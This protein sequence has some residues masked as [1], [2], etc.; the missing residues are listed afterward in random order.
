MESWEPLLL[1]P[2]SRWLWK[3]QGS[4]AAR[5]GLEICVQVPT[6]LRLCLPNS[7]MDG[8]RVSKALRD[9]VYLPSCPPGSPS[10]WGRSKEPIKVWVRGQKSLK[11]V[12][13]EPG[14]LGACQGPGGTHPACKS[15]SESGRDR[16]TFRQLQSLP[17]PSPLIPISDPS[18]ASKT[19]QRLS[20]SIPPTTLQVTL[21]SCLYDWGMELRREGGWKGGT[22]FF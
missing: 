3:K 10:T 8:W 12:E 7:K 5:T 9:L 1:A 6:N 20:I 18:T 15:F 19:H 4:V 14:G 13:G 2:R 21:L 22:F 17:P 11:C 16:C